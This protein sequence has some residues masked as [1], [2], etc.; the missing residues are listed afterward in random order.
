MAFTCVNGTRWVVRNGT[1]YMNSCG[2]YPD[3]IKQPE[4]DVATARAH[5][6]D[7]F[8]DWIGPINDACVQDE[9]AWGCNPVGGLIP[10]ECVLA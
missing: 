1:L 10:R 8:G 4:K 9:C 3:F 6:R 5:W 2:M 7:W